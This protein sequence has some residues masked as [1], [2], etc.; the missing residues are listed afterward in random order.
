MQ[1]N[2]FK[3]KQLWKNKK[4][5]CQWAQANDENNFLVQKKR[6]EEA[7]FEVVIVEPDASTMIGSSDFDKVIRVVKGMENDWGNNPPN[8]R[9]NCTKKS[10]L[11]YFFFR[12]SRILFHCASA[13]VAASIACFRNMSLAC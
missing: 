2:K 8:Q 1:L 12:L 4:A 3:F 13:F 5:C 10:G 6:A 7:G 9:S 11:N